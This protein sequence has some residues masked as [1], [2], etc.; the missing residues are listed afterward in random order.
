MTPCLDHI[1]LDIQEH[2]AGFPVIINNPVIVKDTTVQEL[3]RRL[4][5]QQQQQQQL[6]LLGFPS[7]L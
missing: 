6:S 3:T 4:D 2:I 1:R 5:V 7:V